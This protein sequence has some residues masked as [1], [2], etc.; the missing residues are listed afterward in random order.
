MK[1]SL[2][3]PSSNHSRNP[4]MNVASKDDFSEMPPEDMLEHNDNS[5]DNVSF[6]CK[7]IITLNFTNLNF[8]LKDEFNASEISKNDSKNINDISEE[9]MKQNLKQ[10]SK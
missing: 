9:E 6:I 3:P 4:S 1:A 7:S 10:L 2:N 8:Y 5:G